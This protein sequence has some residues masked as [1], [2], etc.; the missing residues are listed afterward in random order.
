[1]GREGVVAWRRWPVSKLPRQNTCYPSRCGSRSIRQ[2][3]A[4]I[5]THQVSD[6][7]SSS[8]ACSVLPG[9]FGCKPGRGGDVWLDLGEFSSSERDGGSREV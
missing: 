8:S 2:H 3:F 9:L 7:S 5:G 6:M 1:M 4:L